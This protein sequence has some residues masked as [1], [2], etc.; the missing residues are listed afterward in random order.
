MNSS[1]KIPN[2]LHFILDVEKNVY[3]FLFS[4]Y[5]SIYSAYLLNKP[6]KIYIW[7]NHLPLGSWWDET[8]KLKNI[9]LKKYDVPTNF[10]N[11]KIVEPEHKKDFIKLNILY[12]YGGVYMDL[13]SV[14]LK[15]YRDILLNNTVMIQKSDKELYSGFI[16]TKPKSDFLKLWLKEYKEK[17]KTFET[18]KCSEKIPLKIA[19]KNPFK[20]LVLS[21]EYINVSSKNKDIFEKNFYI[22]KVT[23][24]IPFYDC[25]FELKKIGDTK[26]ANQNKNSLYSKII[27]KLMKF[28][29]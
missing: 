22:P 19:A 14:S 8:L 23:L 27:L 13:E 21:N 11:K 15:S 26:W 1:E 2:I 18:N 5:L 25:K 7:Y 29:V 12:N 20:L 10:Y 6:K 28:N 24:M 16:A 9:E 4:Y 3:P 17:F